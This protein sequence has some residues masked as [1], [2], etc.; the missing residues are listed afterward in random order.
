MNK[1][2]IKQNTFEPIY[3]NKSEILILGSFPSEISR[4]RNFYYSNKHNRF[5]DVLDELYKHNFKTLVI[6]NK[7]YEAVKT[8]LNDLHI[9]LYDV[10]KSC[11]IKGSLDSKLYIKEYSDKLKQIIDL[12]NIKLI[13]FNG[14]KAYN[15]F[16][17]EFK[18]SISYSDEFPRYKGKP[19]LKMPSTSPA[20]AVFKKDM[21]VDK[22]KKMIDLNNEI[23]K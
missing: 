19:L 22:Y 23:K 11:S 18:S 10:V 7:D 3:T 5:W 21:L 9:A 16:I 14:T 20:N 17:K 2:D 1:A 13:V 8:K 4:A 12:D 15:L 6:N